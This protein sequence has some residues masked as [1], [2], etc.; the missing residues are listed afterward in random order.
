MA[1]KASGKKR[2]SSNEMDD[3]T[4][5]E[6]YFNDIDFELIAPSLPPFPDEKICQA[7]SFDSKVNFFEVKNGD[8]MKSIFFVEFVN[9]KEEVIS[10]KEQFFAAIMVFLCV[11]KSKVIQK[12]KKYLR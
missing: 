10:G 8:K 4:Q 6:H 3:D 2:K 12:I 9:L 1:G 7:V 5:D 11:K